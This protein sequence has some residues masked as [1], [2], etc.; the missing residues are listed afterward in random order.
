MD[1]VS[2]HSDLGVTVDR[3]LKFHSHISK[4]VAMANNITTNLLACTLNRD[5]EFLINV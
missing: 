5:S 1:F 3:S 4:K 2:S